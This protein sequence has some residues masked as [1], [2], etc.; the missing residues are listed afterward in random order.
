M[1]E[2]TREQLRR[3]MANDGRPRRY[4]VQVRC[5]RGHPLVWVVPMGESLV[6]VGARPRE[7]GKGRSPL[8]YAEAGPDGFRPYGLRNWPP[9]VDVPPGSCRCGVVKWYSAE[10]LLRLARG[11]RRKV[12][13]QA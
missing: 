11:T 2:Y 1:S 4:V 10:E 13:L 3:D 12:L 9:G 7:S 8:L 5:S 6:P